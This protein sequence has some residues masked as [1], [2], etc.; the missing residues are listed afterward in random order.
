V[1]TADFD[2]NEEN[3]GVRL[4][5]FLASAQPDLSRTRLQTFISEGRVRVNGSIA[6]A[7]QRVQAGDRVAVDLPPTREATL[8][9]E[10]M[11]LQVVH[12]DEH[13]LVLDKPAGLIVHPGAGVSSGT[14]VHGLLHRDPEIAGVGGENRPGIVHRLDKDTSGLIVIARTPRAYRSL[15]QA[16]KE[17]TVHR[18][19]AALVWGDP[20]AEEGSI[21]APIGR[22]PRDRRRMAVVARGGKPART[23]WRVVERFGVATHLDV[24]LETGRTHQIRVHLAHIRHPVVGDPVYG[25]RTKKALSLELGQR[26]LA[27]A[28]LT[29]LGR[30]A[31]HARKL[32][33]DHPVSGRK[34]RLESSLPEDFG[35]ALELL[36]RPRERSQA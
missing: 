22:D 3:S 33:F 35:R 18:T 11:E 25:G 21:D 16:L 24:D 31:L 15:V 17:R 27:A 28:V 9:P 7:S 1:I 12:E 8:G 30:Q 29:E 14:L 32:E 5:R 6:K 26:S 23:H 13:V 19:Y 20:R 2:V 34:M 10:P 36:R 4:D